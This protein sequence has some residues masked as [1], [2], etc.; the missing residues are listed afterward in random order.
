MAID[1][2][3]ELLLFT[4]SSRNNSLRVGMIGG[5]PNQKG[6]GSSSFSAA[7]ILRFT[8]WANSRTVLIA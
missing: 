3:P 8:S 4:A 5:G 2:A 7:S 1:A 6:T